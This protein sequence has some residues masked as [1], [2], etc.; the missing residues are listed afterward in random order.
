MGRISLRGTENSNRMG[1]FLLTAISTMVAIAIS[2][3][4]TG[5]A[6]VAAAASA[7]VSHEGNPTRQFGAA[8][9]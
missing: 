7:G 1:R 9:S 8:A 2:V 6:P 5:I 4:G 3:T